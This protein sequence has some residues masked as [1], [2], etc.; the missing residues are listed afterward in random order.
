MIRGMVPNEIARMCI[1]RTAR[2]LEA[3]AIPWLGPDKLTEGIRL[4]RC[5]FLAFRENVCLAMV[6]LPIA[7]ACRSI[8]ET[9]KA[10]LDA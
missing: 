3:L 10:K 5:R 9:G 4:A 7:V 8:L 1:L 2:S 6:C